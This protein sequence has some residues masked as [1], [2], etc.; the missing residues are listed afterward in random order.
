MRPFVLVLT[1]SACSEYAVGNPVPEP[2]REPVPA[3]E[4]P[5]ALEPSDPAEPPSPPA[6]SVDVPPDHRAPPD[7]LDGDCD[8]AMIAPFSEDEIWVGSRSRTSDHGVL[9]APAS[10]WY[11]LYNTHVVESGGS[12]HNE[13]AY[14]RLRNGSNPDGRPASGNCGSD[15][16]VVD[17]DNDGPPPGNQVFLGTFWL[18]AG[19]NDLELRHYCPRF[20]AGD[21][22]EH[23]VPT[24]SSQSCESD[25]INSVHFTGF[26][27]CL[28]PVVP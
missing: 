5:D 1:V 10:G 24:P 27:V 21:C 8:P 26:A 17:L 19:D 7:I 4:P 11:D 23:H 28:V 6:Q 2:E 15:H 20:R 16:V 18:D 22:P 13:S 12:Q 25:N 3:H 9:T 14:V